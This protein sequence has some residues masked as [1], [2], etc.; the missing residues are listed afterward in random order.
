MTAKGESIRL[1]RENGKRLARATGKGKVFDWQGELRAKGRVFDWQG[2]D[3]KGERASGRKGESILLARG[4]SG[5]KG[6]NISLQRED[7]GRRGEYFCWQ[8]ENG[9]KG[10]NILLEKD[11]DAA[12]KGTMFADEVEKGREFCSNALMTYSL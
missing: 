1:A 4:K 2:D 5:R 3:S 10:E 9:R 6:E 11:L 7:N 8:G 12:E